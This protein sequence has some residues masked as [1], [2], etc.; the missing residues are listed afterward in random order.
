MAVICNCNTSTGCPTAVNIAPSA[1]PFKVGDELTCS[2]DGYD[3]TY[4]WTGTHGA[5][6]IAASPNP[7][8]L[9]AAGDF[10]LTCTATVNELT[11]VLLATARIT[12]TV[13]SKYRKHRNTLATIPVLMMTVFVAWLIDRVDTLRDGANNNAHSQAGATTNNP[14]TGQWHTQSSSAA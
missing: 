10:D 6:S 5:A 9:S 7:F 14:T 4:T 1:G 13:Y 2:S 11:C 8:T 12:G 3:P